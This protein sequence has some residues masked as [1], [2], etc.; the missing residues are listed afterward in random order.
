MCT[1][2]DMSGMRRLA[3]L[4]PALVVFCVGNGC[5][6]KRTAMMVAVDD[7]GPQ[8]VTKN[9][10][11]ACIGK[12]TPDGYFLASEWNRKLQKAQPGVFAD[13]GIP[14]VFTQ[15][16]QLPGAS[17]SWTVALAPTLVLPVCWSSFEGESVITVDVLDNPDAHAA[18][19]T[20]SRTD[21]A[22]ALLSPFP[23][24]CYLGEAGFD[25]EPPKNRK[26]I[27][28]DMG[29][30]D[31]LGG[32]DAMIEYGDR[33]DDFGS[34][35]STMGPARANA[36]GIAVML[37]Q[38]EDAGKIDAS[39]CKMQNATRQNTEPL[40]KA[41]FELLDLLKEDDDGLRYAFS[42]KSRSGNV[43]L[44]ESRKAQRE[45]RRIIR[46]D[47]A[48]SHPSANRTLLVVDFTEYALENEVIKGRATILPLNVLSFNYDKNTRR[49]VMAIRVD[50]GQLEDARRYV[51]Q[52]IET[53]V[54]DKNAVL[55][56]GDVPPDA[57]FYLLGESVTN[58]VLKV[59]FKTE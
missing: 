16:F 2:A 47:F 9:R 31:L 14:F 56:S 58:G 25:D 33:I 41:D 37:K 23:M 49:G 6:H 3:W 13:N 46:N 17:T 39:R 36:Y 43:S 24:L 19:K 11:T 51:R 35:G 50:V 59:D 10:Y 28:H 54:R 7:S 40:V 55:V 21:Y 4:G 53:V 1:R 5:V 18:F 30:I 44:R 8:I 57:T 27:R 29:L 38:M 26:W 20:A 12:A 45:L 15:S 42:L 48:A 32:G 34:G 22:S 52:N